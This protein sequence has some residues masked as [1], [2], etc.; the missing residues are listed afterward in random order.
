MPAVAQASSMGVFFQLVWG[1]YPGICS[2][3]NT[4]VHLMQGS[5]ERG[6]QK[7]RTRAT[8]L[9]FLELSSASLLG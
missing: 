7:R 3:T 5:T 8:P 4:R 1:S 2:L 9:L 6:L